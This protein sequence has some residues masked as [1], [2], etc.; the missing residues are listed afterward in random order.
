MNGVE[1]EISLLRMKMQERLEVVK[2]IAGCRNSWASV[3]FEQFG[4]LYFS[5]DVNGSALPTLTHG[6]LGGIKV[7]DPRSV[8][9]PSLGRN[10]F[11]DGQKTIDCDRGPCKF[12]PSL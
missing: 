1:L 10:M 6:D 4:S 5:E 11:E 2:A 12:E 7:S 9:G 3:S 8:I